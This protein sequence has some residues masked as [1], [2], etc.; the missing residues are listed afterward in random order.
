VTFAELG[1]RRGLADARRLLGL[2]LGN[3]GRQQEARGALELALIDADASGD[4]ERRRSVINTLG[5]HL[6]LGPAPVSEG[7]AFCE[8]LIGSTAGERVL[9]A[10]LNRHLGI[11]YAM[12]ARHDEA[13]S[14]L[15][16]SGTVLDEV[17]IR[18]LEVWRYTVAYAKVLC[19]D[20]AG[21]ELELRRTWDYFRP[22]RQFDGR[23]WRGALGLAFLL[24]DQGRFDEAAEFLAYGGDRRSD[25]QA[26][27][28]VRARLAAGEGRLDDAVVLA[29]R[30]IDGLDEAYAVTTVELLDAA[31]KVQRAAGLAAEADETTRR[32]LAICER[33]GNLGAAALL[34]ASASAA[35]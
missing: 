33:K 2:S 28:S 30:S 4:A 14:A 15:A 26:V 31:A 27:L 35:V 17:S 3:S 23:A 32:G 21:A 8:G 12:A 24:C 19:G 9:E 7:I 6:I 1:D 25:H 20:L 34:R 10:T 5:G 11:H 16:R 29:A 18:R 22:I 13:L